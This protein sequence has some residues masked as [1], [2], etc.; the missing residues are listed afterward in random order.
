VKKVLAHRYYRLGLSAAKQRRLSEALRYAQCASLL[1]PENNDASLLAEICR[2][3][4]GGSFGE[5]SPLEQ[6]AVL[7]KQKNWAKAARVLEKVSHQSVRCV[8]IQGCL[9][10]LVKRRALSAACFMSA[11]AKDRGNPLALEALA[12]FGP[13]RSNRTLGCVPL[14]RLFFWRFF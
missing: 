10:A 14:E 4:L 9:W 2:Y 6:A 5:G 13:L 12:E 8:C 3:E 7:M 11:L 1:D